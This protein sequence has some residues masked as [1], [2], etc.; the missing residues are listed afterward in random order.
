M[1]DYDLPTVL[2]DIFYR[3]NLE[4]LKDYKKF[5]NNV[6]RDGAKVLYIPEEG[7]IRVHNDGNLVPREILMLADEW[8]L[9][10]QLRHAYK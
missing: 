4:E 6:E 5:K 8:A 9:R 1:E 7:I 10:M 2:L 3:G